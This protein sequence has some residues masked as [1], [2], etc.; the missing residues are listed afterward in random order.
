MANQKLN[1]TDQSSSMENPTSC[2]WRFLSLGV[3]VLT[4]ITIIPLTCI[5]SPICFV[6]AQGLMSGT[7]RSQ[8]A[9]AQAQLA[10]KVFQFIEECSD[11]GKLADISQECLASTMAGCNKHWIIL[12]HFRA[13]IT[14]VFSG[15]QPH[16]STVVIFNPLKQP[17]SRFQE[18]KGIC[19]ETRDCPLPGVVCLKRLL[20]CLLVLCDGFMHFLESFVLGCNLKLQLIKVRLHSLKC[21]YLCVATCYADYASKQRPRCLSVQALTE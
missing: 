15:S 7:S 12:T 16:Q 17:S 3:V 6:L 13:N 5:V 20:V 19:H 14:F 4:L 21:K 10:C 2:G 1:G 11:R 8:I 9:L 18:Q